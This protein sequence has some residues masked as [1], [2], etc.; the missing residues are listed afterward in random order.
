MSD[1]TAA[2][3]GIAAPATLSI[4]CPRP[5]TRVPVSFNVN[6]FHQ[7]SRSADVVKCQALHNGRVLECR[8][9]KLTTGAFTWS[10][11]LNLDPG[12]LDGTPI[13]LRARL[14]DS[15]GLLIFGPF[16][17]PVVLD[18]VHPDPLCATA[19]DGTVTTCPPF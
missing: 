14:E 2:G 1:T 17:V 16:V 12:L 10:C 9:C 6:G 4:D 15:S 19:G 13:T 3:P 7:S 18:R 5:G 8:V 11:K